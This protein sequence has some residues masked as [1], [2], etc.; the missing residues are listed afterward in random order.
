MRGRSMS[1]AV[2]RRP[3]PAEDRVQFEA[4]THELLC[5]HRGTGTQYPPSTTGFSL[6]L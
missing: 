6:S 2:S 1:Q 5:D 4:C 3:F